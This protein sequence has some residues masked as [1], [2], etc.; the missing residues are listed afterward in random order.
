MITKIGEY[1]EPY[2]TLLREGSAIPSLTILLDNPNEHVKQQA[3]W[4][5]CV[6]FEEFMNRSAFVENGG[7]P[8]LLQLTHSNHPG[9]RL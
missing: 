3:L 2:R 5:L 6:L 4:A 8:R 1:G 9:M 7:F